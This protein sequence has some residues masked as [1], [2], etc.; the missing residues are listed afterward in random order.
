MPRRK[1]NLPLI[2]VIGVSLLLHVVGLLVLGGLTIWQV[3]Q[4]PE[5]E[6]EAPPPPQEAIQPQ[7]LKVR[8]QK[9]QQKSRQPT[10]VMQVQNLSNLNLPK[11]DINM[12]TVD[13]R[14]SV[15][16]GAGG[17]GIGRGFGA[18]GLD[19]SK[20]A[21][22][23]FG[24]KSTGENIVFIVDVT[25]SMLEPKRGDVWGFNRVKE[26]I[27]NMIDGLS[28][29]T[30][31]NIYA[32]ERGLDVYSVRPMPATPENKEAAKKWINQYWAFQGTRIVG[33]QGAN[34]NNYRPTFTEDM[35]VRR[36]KVITKGNG[37]NWSAE[38]VP[39]PE[40]QWGQGSNS[41]SR[42]ELALLAAFENYADTIFIIT[43]GTPQVAR[44]IKQEEFNAWE[45]ARAKWEIEEEKVKG[46]PKWQAYLDKRREYEQKVAAYKEERRKKG[47]PPE[48][49]ENSHIGGIRP[50]E[51]PMGWAPNISHRN[52]S[53]KDINAFLRDRAR[54][55]YKERDRRPPP[56]HIVGY[57]VDEKAQENLEELQKGFPSSKFRHLKS[58][59]LKEPEK[60]EKKDE[61]ESFFN[62]S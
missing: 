33:R 55:L 53:F 3:I 34:S 52:M 13:S 48:I 7:E 12:P 50:P 6:F 11:L 46:T 58:E 35:D 19:M 54:E 61:K 47:L 41:T 23:F 20:S 5:P 49:R 1:V 18:G 29:G 38:L 22:N 45:R 10:R 8:L 57:G 56:M 32:Y 40:E 17:G 26:E 15:S 39:I 31:F 42:M 9:T 43:D 62:P 30:L 59:D 21:V 36:N 60:E 44:D 25:R 51:P 4:Q 24:I 14:V 37:S 16:A 27:G 2:E 28:P